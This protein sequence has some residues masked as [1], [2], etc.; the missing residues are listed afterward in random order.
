MGCV[1]DAQQELERW[2]RDFHNLLLVPSTGTSCKC[3]DLIAK[4]EFCYSSMANTGDESCVSLQRRRKDKTKLWVPSLR[5]WAIN[6]Y[7]LSFAAEM[8]RQKRHPNAKVEDRMIWWCSMNFEWM[9]AANWLKKACSRQPDLP[10]RRVGLP[11][12]WSKTSHS[13]LRSRGSSI[14]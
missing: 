5:M 9:L 6:S 13:I 11:F 14:N 7:V 10:Q 1:T 12:C 3:G 2:Q 4:A 8:P